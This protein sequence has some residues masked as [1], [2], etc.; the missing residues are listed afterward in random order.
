MKKLLALLLLML[1]LVMGC[2]WFSEKP[3]HKTVVL[4][5]T[6]IYINND[7]NGDMGWAKGNEVC[8]WGYEQDGKIVIDYYFLTQVKTLNF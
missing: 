4:P 2:A 5:E 7:C 3:F 6:I 8:A 1:V